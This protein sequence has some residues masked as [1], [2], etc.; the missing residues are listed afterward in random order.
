VKA[1]QTKSREMSKA[2]M[3]EYIHSLRGSLRQK[4]GEKPFADWLADLNREEK[5]LEE[6]K[7]LRMTC[8]GLLSATRNSRKSR[9][10]LKSTG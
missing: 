3:R 6:A 7:F 8:A 1:R 4:P 9:K 10:I 5:E 2:A